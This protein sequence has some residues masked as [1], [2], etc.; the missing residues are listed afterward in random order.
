MFGN[1]LLLWESSCV[2]KISENVD[3]S[4]FYFFCKQFFSK[5]I[6]LW[7]RNF[8]HL[9]LIMV[10]SQLC[11]LVVSVNLVDA[12]CGSHAYDANHCSSMWEFL[13]EIMYYFGGSLWYISS[14]FIFQMGIILEDHPLKQPSISDGVCSW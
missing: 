12:T 7:S 14:F 8:L 2:L 9:G 11:S 1:I 5:I 3:V 6:R 13:M 4:L 10:G